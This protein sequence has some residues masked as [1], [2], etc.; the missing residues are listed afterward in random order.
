MIRER[1]R[2]LKW[3][4]R[5]ERVWVGSG[6]VCVC[7]VNVKSCI[8]GVDKFLNE[9]MTLCSLKHDLFYCICQCHRV[10]LV[11]RVAFGSPVSGCKFSDVKSSFTFRL[12]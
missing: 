1:M 8:L 6:G 11:W 10:M 9:V 3:G 4:K 12:S 2:G 7:V 5:G